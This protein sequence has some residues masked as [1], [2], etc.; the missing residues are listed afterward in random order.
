MTHTWPDF[1]RIIKKTYAKRV[2]IP[3]ALSRSTKTGEYP[4]DGYFEE[5]EGVHTLAVFEPKLSEGEK[6]SWSDDNE[7]RPYANEDRYKPTDVVWDDNEEDDLGVRLAFRQ[8][9]PD[10][11]ALWHL[12]QDVVIAL[13]L[14]REGDEW[15][16]PSESYQTVARV[17]R[18]A[19]HCEIGIE[20][21][22]EF[23]RDYLCARKC[24]LRICTFRNID[25]VA[26]PENSPPNFQDEEDD[27][28]EGGS[29]SFRSFEL[30]SVGGPA[31]STVAVFK[32]SR[33][34]I[35]ADEDVPEMGPQTD[36][37][38]A[39][40][41]WTFSRASSGKMRFLGE[42]WRD[43]WLAPAKA[44][45]RVRRDRVPSE[46]SFIATSDGERMNADDLNDE[47]VGRWLW[48]KPDIIPSIME[49]RGSALTWY[50]LETGGISTPSEPSV[51]FGLNSIG[52]LTVYA[53]DVARLPE[54]ERR[55]WSGYNTTPEGGVSEELLS[56]QTR[57]EPAD[58]L[59][60]EKY[61]A[62]ALDEL[63]KTWSK[64]FGGELLRTH[65][66]YDE[67]IERCHRFRSL[68]ESGL[69][70]LA[71]DLARIT[72]DL[73]DIK[74]TQA[75][76]QPPQG[77]KWGSLKSFEKALATVFDPEAVHKIVAPL[78]AIYDLRLSDAHLPRSDIQRSYEILR[79]DPNKPWVFAGSGM[80][81]SLVGSIMACCL[82]LDET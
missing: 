3:L 4:K 70:A 38:I 64:R 2:W 37:N 63:S 50:T 34:D 41:S 21:K 12:N 8:S 1:R 47:D 44:S 76:C 9:F 61:L 40:D 29:L 59:A 71:K 48:F 81:K 77:Q 6:R 51:H 19:D 5:F 7:H 13:E 10:R 75:V 39:A 79:V 55:L 31:G 25:M 33:T 20:M 45:I 54:W 26:L 14:A 28:F 36:E 35:D 66:K 73:I 17:I 78:F 11:P 72:A 16:R 58:T 23:L 24:H 74:V 49:R 18:N 52:L 15:L 57:A 69:F 68:S 46:V 42:Y 67:I 32:A 30:D 82:I 80:L 62:R 65:E 60:P 22:S 53:A 56:A 27:N 43:E